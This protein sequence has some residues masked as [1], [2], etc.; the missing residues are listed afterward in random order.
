MITGRRLCEN[1][2]FEIDG[3]LGP[4]VYCHCAMCRR[5]SG[6]AFAANASVRAGAL[7]MVAG[8]E[9]IAEIE[10]SPGAFRGFCSRCGTPLYGRS[11]SLPGVRRVRLGTLDG[12]PGDRSVANIWVG[13]KAPW[14]EI[15]DDLERFDEEPPE[16]YCACG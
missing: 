11:E 6:A 8:G 9:L 14:F 4:I 7:R 15:T 5:A 1:V 3:R 10:S 12:D 2:R 16:S 13:S